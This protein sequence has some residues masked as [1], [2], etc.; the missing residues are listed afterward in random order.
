M[1][2]SRCVG[3]GV[4]VKVNIAVDG[5]RSHRC[6]RASHKRIVSALSM[7]LRW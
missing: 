7:S 5:F 4:R 6:I 2:F 1:G 3:S